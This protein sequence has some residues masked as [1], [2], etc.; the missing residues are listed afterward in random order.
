[1][2]S[3]STFT[4]LS[5]I[6]TLA[7]NPQLVSRSLKGIVAQKLMRKLCPTCREAYQPDAQLLS[8]LNL[9]VE[10][11]KQFY[12]PPSKPLLDKKGNPIICST[13]SGTGYFGRVAAFEIL[14]VNDEVREL[15]AQDAGG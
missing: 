4:A 13:C 5:E 7:G 14:V 15:I 9:P 10:K 2:S 6:M 12:R 3:G 8:R 1:M 11:I